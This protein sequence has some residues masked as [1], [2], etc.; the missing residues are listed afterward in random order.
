MEDDGGSALNY[1][2]T[3]DVKAAIQKAVQYVKSAHGI[4]ATKVSPTYLSE[5]AYSFKLNRQVK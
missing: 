2:V 1:G 3:R 5:Y 4:V